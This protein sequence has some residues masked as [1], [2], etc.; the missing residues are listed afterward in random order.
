MTN[1]IE[2]ALELN[3]LKNQNIEESQTSFLNSVLGKAINSAIDVGIK[4]VL[5]DFVEDQVINVKDNLLKYGLK[6]GIKQTINDALNLGKSAIGIVTGKFENI[7]QIQTAVK[8]G[9]IVDGIS[10]VLDYTINKA[11][12]KGMIKSTVANMIKS[13]KDVIL[14]NVEKGIENTFKQQNTNKTELT[15]NIENW[16]K[17]YQ[18][19]DFAKMEKEYTKIEKEM[20]AL[21]PLENTIKQIRTLENIHNLIKN[22]NQN[23]NLTKDEIELAQKL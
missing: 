8:S 11:K 15:Q 18:E 7:D 9:G 13:G 10:E 2:Q 12:N 5:P 4:A 23:F 1:Q 21:V 19:K 3:N 14:D 16:K 6:D 17:G 22:N 20:K